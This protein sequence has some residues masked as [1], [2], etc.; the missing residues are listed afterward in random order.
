MVAPL[1]LA[2]APL[3]K[4]LAMWGFSAIASVVAAKGKEV[5]EDKF[6]VKL[7][8]LMGSEEGRLTLKKLEIEHQEFL[9]EMAQKSEAREFEYFKAEVEDR[10]SA[11][12]A[13]AEIA[14]NSNSGVLQRT[15]LPV[16][17]YVITLGFFGSMGAL[18]YVSLTGAK[19]DDNSRDILIYA[20][21]AMTGGW[22]LVMNFLYGSS[23]GSR[24]NQEALVVQLS[25]KGNAS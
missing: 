12:S 14:T 7:D 15:L 16:M 8:D 20:F 9:I 6:G 11:R 5:V 10:Q 18:F 24:A 23:H 25:K 1:I 3:L 21:G 17:S 4:D 13:N 22:M 19:L 2:A